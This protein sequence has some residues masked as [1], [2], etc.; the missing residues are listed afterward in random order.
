MSSF[1]PFAARRALTAT[2]LV[3]GLTLAACARDDDDARP[4][5]TSTGAAPSTT[6]ATSAP[7]GS[8]TSSNAFNDADV[9]FAQRMIVHHEQAIEMAEIAQEPAR[10]AGAEV[11]ALA[12]R[13]EAGQDPEIERMIGW[14]R[15]WG[16]PDQMDTSGGHDMSEMAGMMSAEDMDSLDA[17]AGTEFDDMWLT[18]MVE[19]H[20]GAI[21][22]ATDIQAE[23]TNGDVETLAGQIVAAQQAEVDEMRPL[24][25]G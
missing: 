13:I 3:G 16:A 8:A 23:G 25:D 4:T 17:M 18:M 1:N 24:L 6:S 7:T 2:V 21:E 22:M 5:T 20:E 15:S 19:H 14:L 9:E 10:K 11:I 12:G